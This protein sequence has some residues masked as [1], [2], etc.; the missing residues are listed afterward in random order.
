MIIRHTLPNSQ[1]TK[2]DRRVFTNPKLSDGAVRLYAYLCSLRNGANF[3]DTYVCKAMGISKRVLYNRKKELTELD[4]ILVDQISA[5]CYIIYIGYTSLGAKEA[6]ELW[7][8]EDD[9]E[10]LMPNSTE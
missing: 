10:L 7:K 5:R 1:F 4:L 8:A 2:L 3:S 9:T 6:K